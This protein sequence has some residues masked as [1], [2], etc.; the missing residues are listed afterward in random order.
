MPRAAERRA[1]PAVAAER[2]CTWPRCRRAIASSSD[3]RYCRHHLETRFRICTGQSRIDNAG[4]GLFA[5]H[6]KLRRCYRSHHAR[7]HANASAVVFRRGDRI[8]TFAG[9]IIDIAEFE[10]RYAVQDGFAE[11]VLP[12]DESRMHDETHLRTALS[13]ANDA[14]NTRDPMMRRNY[15]DSYGTHV[16]WHDLAWPHYVNA[17]CRYD[18]TSDSAA[19]FAL[20]DIC[21]GEEIFFSYCGVNGASRT[22]SGLWLTAVSDSG[23]VQDAFWYGKMR[24][25]RS[26]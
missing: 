1:S 24:S 19:L 7:P 12:I 20:G 15:V 26:A 13:Y 23:S 16:V 10:R 14:V 18:A 2:R 5:I 3:Y 25:Q 4:L 22:P 6:P 11:Y 8:G 9:E 17:V 21:H